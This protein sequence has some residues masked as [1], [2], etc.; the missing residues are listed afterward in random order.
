[1]SNI[2]FEPRF[3]CNRPQGCLYIFYES[4][5]KDL[6]QPIYKIGY[7]SRNSRDRKKGYPSDTE[8]IYEYYLNLPATHI[9][10]IETM[11]KREF[12]KTYRCCEGSTE[13]FEGSKK[14]F[15]S[16]DR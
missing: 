12:R 5:Y 2:D 4:Q 3:A 7:T 13:R 10:N 9:M 15:Y 16:I 8:I 11:I 1:M 6:G 14:T